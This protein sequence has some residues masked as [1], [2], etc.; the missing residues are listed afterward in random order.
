[1]SAAWYRNQ[2][3]DCFDSYCAE[4][5]LLAEVDVSALRVSWKRS[6]QSPGHRLRQRRKWLSTRSPCPTTVYLLVGSTFREYSATRTLRSFLRRVQQPPVCAVL[7]GSY[8]AAAFLQSIRSHH[9]FVPADLDL[10]VFDDA[11]FDFVVDLYDTMVLQAFQLIADGYLLDGGY[12]ADPDNGIPFFN[13]PH[14]LLRP[15]ITAWC[16][17]SVGLRRHAFAIAEG[18]RR[19][20]THLP[21][22]HQ[23]PSYQVEKCARIQ[24]SPPEAPL[25]LRP[26]N[27]ILV[28]MKRMTALP[29]YSPNLLQDDTMTRR[30]DRHEPF[31]GYHNRAAQICNSFDI[32]AC[33]MALWVQ[34]DHSFRYLSFEGAERALRLCKLELR[35]SAFTR[36]ARDVSMTM[37]RIQKYMQRGFDW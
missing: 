12:F 10:F 36:H 37:R 14:A 28:S 9:T 32:T 26:L 5:Y 6:W 30:H 13:W 33:C 20:V 23:K 31:A 27:V 7:A 4:F 29:A 22:E 24:V 18:L 34:E 1:M 35:P 25:S 21:R 15:A 3:L 19:T 17:D 2:A 11:A 16:Q 8:A